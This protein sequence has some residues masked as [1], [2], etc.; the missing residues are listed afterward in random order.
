M[1]RRLTSPTGMACGMQGAL[2][3][4]AGRANAGRAACFAAADDN[5]DDADAG[6]A[7]T[8]Q[9][10]APAAAACCIRG[11]VRVSAPRRGF[12]IA[13]IV[14][15]G[16][17]AVA[18]DDDVSAGAAGSEEG[19]DGCFRGP[20]SSATT[21]FT[22]LGGSGEPPAVV[23]GASARRGTRSGILQAPQ[24]P[25]MQPVC[26]AIP[27]GYHPPD[28]LKLSSWRSDLTPGPD[29][30]R[31]QQPAAASLWISDPSAAAA[32]AVQP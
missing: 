21:S 14:D 4:L 23:G 16:G 13:S 5:D 28:L 30:A 15:I 17:G 32:V 29:P 31:H 27:P 18:D 10:T 19:A 20:L 7:A 22:R 8:P 1:R 12:D 26:T 9:G 3:P 2:T 24:S 11:R 25:R 6:T